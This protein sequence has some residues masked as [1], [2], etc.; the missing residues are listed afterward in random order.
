MI[1]HFQLGC[2]MGCRAL[3]EER[4]G[5]AFGLADPMASAIQRFRGSSP[6]AS[7]GTLALAKGAGLHSRLLSGMR[8]WP[9]G[10]LTLPQIS[11]S[12]GLLGWWRRR[13]TSAGQSYRLGRM[14]EMKILDK[15]EQSDRTPNPNEKPESCYCSAL[16]KGSGLCVPCYTRWL[17]G[18]R[19]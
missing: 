16:P 18:K 2:P 1:R 11:A 19:S 5:R 13:Q 14:A 15:T 3:S 6:R 7:E 10:M 12:G 4:R 9:V 8:R 17:A